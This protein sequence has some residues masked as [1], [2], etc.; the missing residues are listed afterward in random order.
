MLKTPCGLLKMVRLM[1]TRESISISQSRN[2]KI[3]TAGGLLQSKETYKSI[4]KK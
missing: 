4:L 3:R 2:G 1:I